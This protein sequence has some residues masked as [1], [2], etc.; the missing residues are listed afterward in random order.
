MFMNCNFNCN[1]LE[2][3]AG[4]R[5]FPWAR[6]CDGC[7]ATPSMV[8]CR[9]DAAYLCASCDAQVHSANRVASRHERVRVC[10]ICE[11]APAVLACRAD[12]AALC[13]TCDAQVHS[14][15]PIAQRHQ[16]VP[17]L[18]LSAVAIS[19]ASGFAEVR[20]AT[21]HGDKEEGEEVDSWLLLR[22]N[23]D[24][25]NCS[26]SIDRYFNLVGYNPYYDNAT[27][28][29]GPGEQYR[30]QEQQVQNRYR[31]KEGSECVVP[32][33]I[34]MASEE[35]ESGYRIIGTE[36]AAFMTVGASTYTASISNSISF[37]SME[38]GIVP[39]NTRPD[40][41]K[42]N[43]LTTSGAMELSVHSV[44]MPVHFSSM[45]RE[46]RVLRYKEKKQAR[47]FQKTIRYA[48]RKAYAEARPRVKGRFAKRSDIEHEVNHMLSPPVLPESSYGTVPWF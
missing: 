41:S 8:Y 24:D 18:P 22:R 36:Q 10:E 30:L 11:S 34:V 48:T 13:T 39:D 28:N 7:H 25:N 29:P 4:R 37:S 20:A 40:I 19:A 21:I 14:A 31:E 35:Q 12:A 44:Q 33:Q 3:E 46:A 43:I 45:D 38:V 6:P 5:N 17:V 15:N 23:S 2:Q 9:V 16:R 32:S 26:N 27:C 47:K 42:T 1:L